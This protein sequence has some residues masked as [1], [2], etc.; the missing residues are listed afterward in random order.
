MSTNSSIAVLKS[1]GTVI[2]T[3]CHFDGYFSHMVEALNLGHDSYEKALALVSGGEIESIG[4]R[5]DDGTGTYDWS[6]VQRFP[7][8]GR[9]PS[10]VFES[11][12]DYLMNE[13]KIP[14]SGYHY[15][16]KDDNW[17]GRCSYIDNKFRL[18]E[19]L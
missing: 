9:E 2:A 3:Y 18:L 6:A 5:I 16:F 19:I 12:E 8:G 11:Y 14:A 17:Y 10:V 7:V 4:A 13:H 1:D 15:I